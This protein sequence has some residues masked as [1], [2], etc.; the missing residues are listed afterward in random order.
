MTDSDYYDHS[1]INK[2]RQ[3]LGAI[4][5][6]LLHNSDIISDLLDNKSFLAFSNNQHLLEL[7]SYWL[8]DPSFQITHSDKLREIINYLKSFL[9]RCV[10]R[11]THYGIL[12]LVN[13]KKHLTISQNM[14]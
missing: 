13:E 2:V 12:L 4:S 8:K 5:T 9:K 14:E 6:V 10:N 11:N 1:D 3:I 7:I